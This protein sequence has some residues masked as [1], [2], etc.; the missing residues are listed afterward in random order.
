MNPYPL[1]RELEKSL[2]LNHLETVLELHKR[3]LHYQKIPYLPLS[4]GAPCS[5]YQTVP[6]EDTLADPEKM[7]YNELIER[8]LSHVRIKDH[9]LFTI[10]A[11]HGTVILPSLFG[12]SYRAFKDTLPWIEHVESE[13]DIKAIIQAGIPNFNAGLGKLV[14]EA[15][16][17]YHAVLKDYPTCKKA[18]HI[19]HPDLQGPFDVAHLIWGSD[20]YMACYENPALIHKLMDL[21]TQTYIEFMKH[22][23]TQINDESDGLVY[24]WGLVFPGKIV[25]RNDSAVN[26]SP[27]MYET[28]VKP[29]D[30]RILDAFG[31]GSIHYCGKKP[32]W[33]ASM[34]ASDNMGAIN[35]G[36]VPGWDY[37]MNFLQECYQLF[38]TRRIAHVGWGISQSE[39]QLLKQSRIQTGVT[40]QS[41]TSTIHDAQQLIE[42][43]EQAA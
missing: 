38:E 14:Q 21:V 5:D 27:D 30:Q 20:I 43:W 4:M 12:L 13:S 40:L 41:G 42:Q 10:R 1:L 8:V 33:L 28:F 17:Y 23:K 16:T 2:D 19:M 18:I 26:L 6:H 35:I 32:A 29:Y 31:G 9:A 15:H 34:I 37:G 3:T 25:L 22:I 7:L 39:L 36:Q 24:H 11:N